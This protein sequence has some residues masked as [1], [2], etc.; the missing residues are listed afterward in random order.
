MDEVLIFSVLILILAFHVK[1]SIF[2]MDP[3]L[4][5]NCINVL[6]PEKILLCIYIL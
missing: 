5:K 2:R 1:N 4:K 6:Q 3:Y